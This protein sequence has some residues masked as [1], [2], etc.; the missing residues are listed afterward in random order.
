MSP[1]SMIETLFSNIGSIF[2]RIAYL[3]QQGSDTAKKPWLRRIVVTLVLLAIVVG[4]VFLALAVLPQLPMRFWQVLGLC[5]VVAVVLWWFMAGQRKASLKGRTRKRIGDLGPASDEEERAPVARMTAAITE[6]KRTIARAPEMAQG[7][8]PLYRI[9]W[10]LFIGDG[11]ANVD[12]LLRA[13]SEVSPFPASDKP[14][15]DADDVWRWWFHKSMIAIEMHPRVVC[16]SSA[17]LDRGLWYQGLMKLADEREKLPLNGLVVAVSVQSLLGPADALKETATR[18][19]RLVDEAMEH[20]QV[21]MPVYFVVSGLERLP[22]YAQMRAT[23]PDEAF[24]QALGHRFTESENTNAAASRRIDEVIQPIED[25]LHA[26]RM[27]ALRAQH[28]PQQR[29]AVFDFIESLRQARPG[30]AMF[31]SL[32]LE[33]NPFQRTPRWR[34]LYF[35]GAADAAHRSGAFVADLFTRFLPS[36]QPLAGTSFRGNAGRMAIAGAGVLAMLG[37]SA[38]FAYGLKSAHRDDAALL[39]QT[40]SACSEVAH[41][42]STGRIEWVASCGRTIEELE[43]AQGDTM[44]SFGIRRADSDIAKLRQRVVDDFANLILAPEDQMLATDIDQRRAGI[45][46]VL[47]ITQRLRLLEDCDSSNPVCRNRELKNNVSFDARSRLFAPF[48]SADNDTRRDRNNA[49]ALF[50]TYLGYLRWQKKNIREAEHAR[51]EGLLTRLLANYTPRAADLKQWADARGVGMDLGSFWLPQGAVVGT[52]TGQLA[53]I[54]SAYTRDTWEGAIEPMLATLRK[55]A[56]E[57]ASRIDD[58]RNA[59]FQDYFTQWE[60]FQARFGDGITLWRGRYEELLARAGGADNPYARFF[61]AAQRNLYELPFDWP[62]ASRWAATWAQMKSKWL[63]SWRPF[64]RF[65]ADSFRFGGEKVTPPVWL[66]AMHD[67]QAVVLNRQDADYA[68]AYLR[69]QAEGSG[70]DVYQLASDLFTSKGKADKPPAS[71]YTKLIDAVDKPA[72]KY[73]TSFKGDDLAA[74]S[75]V[76]GPSKLLLFLTVHK[77]GTYVQQRWRE[78]VVK[79]LSTLP[80]EQQVDALYGPQGKLSAFVNDWLKPFITEKERLPVKVDGVAIPLSAAYQGMVAAERKFQPVL[81]D[82]APFQAGSFTLTQP[83]QLGALD[84]GAE[85]TVLEVECRERVYRASSA[86]AS[87]A[88]ATAQVFWSPSSCMQARIRIS[89]AAPAPKQPEAAPVQEFDPATSQMQPA[90][91]IAAVPEL[92][93]VRTY[94]GVDG[95]AAL[96]KDFA[97]GAHAFGVEDFRDSYSPAQWTQLRPKLDA[98]GFRGVR[99]FLKVDLSDEMKRY[100]GAS[101]AHAEVPSE[102]LE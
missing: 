54:S 34:G 99:V 14:A 29:R 50:A 94:A 33:D 23:L 101:T 9:P 100:L 64:G 25:R 36:D 71:D 16:D 86:G 3:Y 41:S 76:Q 35:A 84:E 97:N 15:M 4:L 26:L 7:R 22:G 32:M 96:I 5:V 45:E 89:V 82:V 31:V 67:S 53:T 60:K 19:R 85:G 30:L 17:R 93:L 1:L 74:W 92:S 18:L 83:S 98:A 90:A 81:G 43:A 87:L 48:V 38:S 52:E 70:E 21:Q 55:Q 6:A 59:Y 8:T 68:R 56:P 79:P 58:L 95:F 62:L 51:L 10:F 77:A 2:T 91:P 13:G 75:I 72:E 63:S 65:I 11:S 20:L 40:R 102:I 24:A 88:E 37:L 42:T 69:L 28:G 49:D 78:S 73:A 39:Q 66:L 27:T 44:L 46:H 57:R 61:V 12:G 80:P 47:A